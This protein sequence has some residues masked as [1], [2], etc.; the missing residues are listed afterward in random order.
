VWAKKRPTDVNV[1]YQYAVQTSRQ[2][3]VASALVFALD[4]MLQEGEPFSNHFVF[5]ASR[6]LHRLEGSK[7]ATEEFKRHRKKIAQWPK[8]LARKLGGG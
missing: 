4:D 8:Q 3:D 7:L 5:Q 2:G 6:A 1:L